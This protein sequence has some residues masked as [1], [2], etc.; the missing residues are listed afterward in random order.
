VAALLRRRQG[1][2]PY[3][4]LA[5]GIAWLI[6][7]FAVPLYYMAELSLKE[8]SI[9]T[10]YRFTWHF[11]T[12]TSAISDYSEQF[13][14]SFEYAGVATLLALV[15]AYP[16][17]YAIAFRGGR[18]RNALLL[19]V[20]LPFFTTYLVRTLS[21]ETILDDDGWIVHALQTLGL[22]ETN[23]RLLATSTAVV[24]G[25]TYNF[26][27]FMILPLYASLERIDK[28]LHEAAYDLY[29]NR[30][31]VFVRVTLPL[32]APG[33]VAGV[34][35]TFIPAAGDFINA[36][37]LGTPRQ[38]MIGNV[39]QSRYLEVSDYPTAAALSFVLMTLILVLVLIYA[40]IAGTEQLTGAEAKV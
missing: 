11:G 22:V 32:S 29:G 31:D 18:W 23:G 2:L 39:I 16:L 19:A 6:V 34:L 17:A 38:A 10:G 35:L 8:G 1:G 25:I 21:W 9:D 37:L 5:P 26:L 3:L 15:I 30:R 14:R 12:Y 20:I 40:R 13:L 7:F 27:P 24:A 36:E 28:R 33:V 4:L